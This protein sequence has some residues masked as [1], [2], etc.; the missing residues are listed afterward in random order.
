VNFYLWIIASFNVAA[1]G[2]FVFLIF[3][4][5]KGVIDAWGG[6]LLCIVTRGE[7]RSIFTSS[8]S[9]KDSTKLQKIVGVPATGSGS[10]RSARTDM[11]RSLSDEENQD[12]EYSDEGQEEED[13]ISESSSLDEEDEGRDSPTPKGDADSASE[14]GR[15]DGKE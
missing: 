15:A 1:G 2:F 9:T 4:T 3:G 5:S 14:Q 10:G 6:F 7:R 8:G 12:T 11:T 13:H